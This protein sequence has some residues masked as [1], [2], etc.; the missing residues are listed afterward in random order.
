[1]SVDFVVGEVG[2]GPNLGHAEEIAQLEAQVAELI[3]HRNR[4]RE[5]LQRCAALSPDVSDAK[6]EVLL[7]TDPKN[8]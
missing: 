4:L 8:D 7:A 2:F 3:R 6:H 1:M 5:V